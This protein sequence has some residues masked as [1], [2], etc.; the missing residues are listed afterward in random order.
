VVVLVAAGAALI[1]MIAGCYVRRL[2]ERF[3]PP[4]TPETPGTPGT[5]QAVEGEKGSAAIAEPHRVE[6]R[7]AFAAAFRRVPVPAWP[8]VV[9]GAAAAVCGVVAWRYGGGLGPA[10]EPAIMAACLYLA[11]A[12]TALALIDWRTKRLPD[13][14]TLPS[15]PIVMALLVP[16]GGLMHGVYGMLALGGLYAALWFARPGA[17]GLGDVK[18]AGLLGLV[19]GAVGLNAWIVAAI[20]GHLLGAAYAVMLLITRRGTLKSEFPF[21]PFMLAAALAGVLLPS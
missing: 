10:R 16:S 12:G 8:P 9:E 17:L 14:I 2:A 5:P 4:G 11:L 7:E 3:G 19:T 20:G 18:L 13:A 21:G 6:A 15:Y 1:G